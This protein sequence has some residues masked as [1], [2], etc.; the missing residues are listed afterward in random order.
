MNHDSQSKQSPKSSSSD[1]PVKIK[2]P[3]K[4]EEAA[5]AKDLIDELG[6]DFADLDLGHAEAGL[7]FD[8]FDDDEDDDF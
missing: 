7:A 1:K 3:S 6:E 8:D 4:P 2:K 5:F